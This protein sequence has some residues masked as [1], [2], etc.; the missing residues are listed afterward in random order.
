MH[1]TCTEHNKTENDIVIDIVKQ[2]IHLYEV[3]HWNNL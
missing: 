3:M 2:K 1:K